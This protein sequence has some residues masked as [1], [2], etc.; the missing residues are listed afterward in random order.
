MIAARALLRRPLRAAAVVAAAASLGGASVVHA[1]V[2]SPATAC[3]PASCH[4]SPPTPAELDAILADADRLLA[5]YADD[6]T[7]LGRQ[8][9][10]L[11]A[12]MRERAADVR[13][14]DHMWRAADP[15]GF[16]SPVTGD[17]HRVEPAAGTGRV[18]IARGFDAL[19]PDRGLPAIVQTAR[20]EFAHLN[21]SRQ[22]EAWGVDAAERL[23]TACAPPAVP[24]PA[25]AAARR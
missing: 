15:D 18:H 3:V 24:P 11:G 12:T 9:H 23:A 17:A 4:I 13:M 14:I 20:H 10:A 1:A 21:G 7:P 25:F 22:S 6:R 5:T 16:F 19:N 8:C 2:A